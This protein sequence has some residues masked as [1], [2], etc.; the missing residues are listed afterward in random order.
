MADS[1]YNDMSI[2]ELKEQEIQLRKELVELK[3]QKGTRQLVDTAGLRKNRRDI[4]RVL[5]VM[6]Q[7]ED[8]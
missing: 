5:T 3:F 8:D 4:A 6:S 2:E 7:K 1:T